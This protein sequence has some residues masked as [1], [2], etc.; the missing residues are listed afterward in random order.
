MGHHKVAAV[1]LAAG[2]SA[3]LGEPKQLIQLGC[4]TI[5]HHV[6]DTVRKADVDSRYIVLGN[7]AD[8]I[9]QRVDLTGF[10]LISNDDY[11]SGQSTS[12]V[13]AV[14][15]MPAEVSAIIFVLADQPLQRAEVIERLA[16]AY[17]EHPAPIIRPEYREGPGNPVLIDRSLFP[18]LE[19]LS[20]DTGARPILKAKR[21]LIRRIDC[22]E[23]ERPLDVDTLEDL[24][25][26]RI[27]WKQMTGAH[28][29]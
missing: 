6:L 10:A 7:A 24:E 18:D 8:E 19:K 11:A 17:R 4:R 22:S 25:Q 23:W 20:G 29:R 16:G 15:Q 3:R 5:L 2:G 27:A 9:Q 26:V 28:D 14:Q 1:V 21:G 12:I 13:A